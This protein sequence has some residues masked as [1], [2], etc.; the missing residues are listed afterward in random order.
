[1]QDKKLVLKEGHQIVTCD[2]CGTILGTFKIVG[3]DF[4]YEH[5]YKCRLCGQ[6]KEVRRAKRKQLLFIKSDNLKTKEGDI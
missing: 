2:N 3:K 5:S 6:I 1:M 4:Y